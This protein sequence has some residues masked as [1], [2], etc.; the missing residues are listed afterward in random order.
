MH[1]IS[2]FHFFILDVTTLKIFRENF[3]LKAPHY[4]V[5]SI[6]LL[7]P[8]SCFKVFLSPCCSQTP[9]IYI[10]REVWQTKFHTRIKQEAEL[11]LQPPL[12]YIH[13]PRESGPFHSSALAIPVLIFLT[14]TL[15][16]VTLIIVGSLHNIYFAFLLSI[17]ISF[18]LINCKH[19]VTDR[20]IIHPRFI[21]QNSRMEPEY[22]Q[23][24]L[25]TLTN[26]VTCFPLVIRLGFRLSNLNFTPHLMH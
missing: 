11:Q 10:L 2:S 15:I 21:S 9:L 17:C 26:C 5:V 23:V 12:A 8:V 20:Q 13:N 6:L 3:N 22:C 7:L 25:P 4:S 24:P 14:Q 19:V 1:I 16:S 18:H